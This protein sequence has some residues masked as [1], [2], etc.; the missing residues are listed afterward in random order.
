MSQEAE[1]AAKWK[2]FEDYKELRSKLTVLEREA[3]TVGLRIEKLRAVLCGS[4]S[5]IRIVRDKVIGIPSGG[6]VL[7]EVDISKVDADEIMKLIREIDAVSKAKA[8][9][10]AK[11]RDLGMSID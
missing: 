9:L 10:V 7:E 8:E 3:S 6:S 11:L 4:P 5:K 2:M 1:M